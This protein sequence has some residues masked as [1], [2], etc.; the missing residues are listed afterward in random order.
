MSDLLIEGYTMDELNEL[1][2]SEEF[3]EL[4]FSNKPVV[5]NAGSAEL[6][7]QFHKD[8]NELH[9][10]LAHIDGGGEGVLITIN[11]LIKKYASHKNITTINWYVNA[12][13]CARPNPKLQRVLKLKNYEVRTIKGKGAVY[14]KKDLI[15]Y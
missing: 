6:L 2:G 14:Y 9:I 3:E 5:F 15:N 11:S 12:T 10:D 7:G 1:I 8:A 4:I 13:N